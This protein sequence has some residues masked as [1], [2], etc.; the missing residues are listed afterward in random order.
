MKFISP[1]IFS[2]LATLCSAGLLATTTVYVPK[3]ILPLYVIITFSSVT[4]MVKK[5]LVDVV[6]HLVILL[7]RYDLFN[8]WAFFRQG[9]SQLSSWALALEYIQP[10]DHKLSSTLMELAGELLYT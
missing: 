8:S 2:G 7:G 6:H 10:L 3:F 5:V 1:L 4:L 9:C